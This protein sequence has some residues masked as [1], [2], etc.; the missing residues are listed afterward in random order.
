[1]EFAAAT[2]KPYLE[3]MRVGSTIGGAAGTLG[4]TLMGMAAPGYPADAL[5][6]TYI[7]YL[8]IHHLPHVSYV[9]TAY[10]PHDEYSPSIISAAVR[11][12]MRQQP[13]PCHRH[14]RVE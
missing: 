14:L 2:D 13:S 9:T 1:M 10:R 11:R 3:P 7:H 8:S 12:T 4:Y 5:T 6:D